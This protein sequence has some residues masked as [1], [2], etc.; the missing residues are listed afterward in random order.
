MADTIEA[1]VAKLQAE[2]VEAGRKEADKL[3]EDARQEA[4]VIVHEAQEQARKIVADAENQAK[5]NLAKGKTELDLAARDSV[6]RLRDALS[7]ILRVV[8]ARE[9]REALADGNF[10]RQLIH[11]ALV[12]YAKADSEN[13]EAV[14]VTVQPEFHAQLA[15]WLMHEVMHKNAVGQIDLKGTLRDAGFEYEI[16]GKNVEVTTSSVVEMLSEMVGPAL[17]KLLDEALAGQGG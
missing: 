17:R 16:A 14:R 2:G 12:Q 1:F 5:A 7:R 9:T 15:D 3:V 13:K 4:E 8:L 6:L 10:L 11:D